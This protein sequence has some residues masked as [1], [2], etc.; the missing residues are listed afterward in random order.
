M[1]TGMLFIV[2]VIIAIDFPHLWRKKLIKELWV[3]S[4]LLLLATVLGIA[5]ALQIKVLNPLDLMI[6]VYKPVADMVD[7]W[8]K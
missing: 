6:T 2:A 5:Q 3:S 8:L 4:I 7:I 1:L